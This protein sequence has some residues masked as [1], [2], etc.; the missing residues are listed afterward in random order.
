MRT[1][2][3]CRETADTWQVRHW[4]AIWNRLFENG[5]S[6]SQSQWGTMT[7]EVILPG[8]HLCSAEVWLRC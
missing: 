6:I 8:S 3:M 7:Q 2:C 5:S 1:V 4:P